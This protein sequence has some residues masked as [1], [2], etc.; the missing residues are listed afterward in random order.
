MTMDPIDSVRDLLG[1][2]ADDKLAEIAG[3]PA[4]R[5]AEARRATAAPATLPTHLLDGTVEALVAALD[6][7]ALDELLAPLQEAEAAGKARKGA[8]T[9]IAA[10]LRQVAPS[11]PQ[12]APEP[13]ALP[14]ERAPAPVR[15]GPQPPAE[16]MVR[17]VRTWRHGRHFYVRSIYRGDQARRILEVVPR[18]LIEVI[19]GQP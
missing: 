14:S 19:A 11:G 13:Q 5:I 7:G 12:R 4:E 10:R 17:V 2:V 1:K 9:A 16:L 6:S 3:V 15:A 8:L 18:D